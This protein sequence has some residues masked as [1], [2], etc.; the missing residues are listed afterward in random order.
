MSIQ[1]SLIIL[2]K[3]ENQKC[4]TN[5]LFLD[6]ARIKEVKAFVI[7]ICI[8][9]TKVAVNVSNHWLITIDVVIRDLFLVANHGKLDSL[10]PQLRQINAFI[11]R[12]SF[13]HS[14]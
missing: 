10:P 6:K 9:L 14:V 11:F 8:I 2:C 12:Q 7:Y 1:I 4:N 3:S 5:T 13:K